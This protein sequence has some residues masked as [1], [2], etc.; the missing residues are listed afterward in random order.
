MLN[1]TTVNRVNWSFRQRGCPLNIELEELI[2]HRLDEEEQRTAPPDGFPALPPIAAGRY[3]DPS[4]AA[5]EQD[6]VF[7]SSWLF[8]GHTSELGRPGDY[9]VA[10]LPIG[11]VIVIRGNDSVVRAFFNSCRHRGAPVARDTCGTAK[12]LICQYH[13]W[14]YDTAGQLKNVPDE[15]DFAELD[16]D[17]RALVALRCEVFD[18]W[19]FVCA[20][21]DTEALESWLGP[22]PDQLAELDGASLRLI[23]RQVADF[24]C[25]WKLAVHAFMEVYHIRTVHPESAALLYDSR[26]TSLAMFER[27]HN[28]LTVDKKPDMA[29]LNQAQGAPFDNDSVGE[30]IRTTSTSYSVFPNVT[31]VPDPAS[32]PFIVAWPTGVDSCRLELTWFGTDWGG[33]DPPREHTERMELFETIVAQ[34]TA[35]LAPMQ[36][37]LR[38]AGCPDILVG[39]Q[40][41]L[42]YHFERH[43]DA[44]IGTSVPSEYRVP[45]VLDHL[46]EHP[47]PA[48]VEASVAR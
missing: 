43:V 44:A 14:A 4:F 19:V 9:R 16:R 24:T 45:P 11:P 15:R 28:R 48:P 35:N 8:A 1:A 21:P 20:S 23:G 30:L 17:D 26:R 12:L 6:H 29:F 18:G 38:S 33:G 46:I 40:E 13:S 5:L 10:E 7:G 42:L 39:Y 37:S 34:D 25:N 41:R 22:I 3:T 36:E 2:R 32:F 27:G 31:I 47:T